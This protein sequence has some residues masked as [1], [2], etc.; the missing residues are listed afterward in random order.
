MMINRKNVKR[1]VIYINDSQ[2]NNLQT[3]LHKI[4]FHYYTIQ[5]KLEGSWEHG[6][7]HLNNHVW[8]GSEAVFHLIVSGDKVD[9]LLKKLKSFRSD[10]PDNVVMAVLVCPLDDFI[11]NMQSVDIEADDSTEK[12]HWLKDAS[13]E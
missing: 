2:K 13:E 4:G 8:P 1:M 11:Y 6:I 12:V 7:R 3:F 10:L 5:S 9:L